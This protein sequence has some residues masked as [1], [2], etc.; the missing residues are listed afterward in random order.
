MG[1]AEPT[2]HQS[3]KFESPSPSGQITTIETN[4]SRPVERASNAALLQGKQLQ[5]LRIRFRDK[6]SVVE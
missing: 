4:Q 2:R 1:S 3:A 5:H 6:S